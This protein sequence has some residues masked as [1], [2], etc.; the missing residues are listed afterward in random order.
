MVIALVVVAF[1]RI[2][3]GF[4]NGV[5]NDGGYGCNCTYVV[6]AIASAA[7]PW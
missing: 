6:A 5:S 1:G 3:S 7:L 2:S 4:L